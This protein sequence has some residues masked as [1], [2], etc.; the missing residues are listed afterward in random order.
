MNK[1]RIF[2][3][4]TLCLAM[5]SVVWAKSVRTPIYIYGFS[6]SFNDSIVYFTDIQKVDSAWLDEKTDFL[7]SRENYSYQLRDFLSGRGEPNRTCVVSYATKRKDIEKKF[8]KMRRKYVEK[9]GYDVKYVSSSEFKFNAMVPSD[10]GLDE[11]ATKAEKKK[12]KERRN[13][14]PQGMPPGGKGGQ[15]EPG[16]GMPPQR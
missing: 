3:A 1:K 10:F 16:G 5:T 12:K 14:P 7:V 9:G 8:I 6:A 13:A 4:L 15:G 11:I 2:L